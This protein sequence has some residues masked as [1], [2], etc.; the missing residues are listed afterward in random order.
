MYGFEILSPINKV[1]ILENF[2][3]NSVYIPFPEF[4]EIKISAYTLYLD[5][6]SENTERLP[7]WPHG[8]NPVGR[9]AYTSVVAFKCFVVNVSVITGLLSTY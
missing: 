5:H 2:V 8:H 1:I 6:M 4:W 3:I 9:G 7:L